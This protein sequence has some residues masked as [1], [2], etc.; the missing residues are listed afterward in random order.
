MPQS[1]AKLGPPFD[2]ALQLQ[3]GDGCERRRRTSQLEGHTDTRELHS[4][5]APRQ[6]LE[7]APPMPSARLGRP[8]D[9]QDWEFFTIFTA[10]RLVFWLAVVELPTASC[11][12]PAG[13]TEAPL[14]AAVLAAA[15]EWSGRQLSA[16]WSRSCSCVAQ[17]RG[18]RQSIDES[19]AL[20]ARLLGSSSEA[21]RRQLEGGSKRQR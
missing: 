2:G 19:S 14:F 10:T 7:A 9:A 16:V 17:S 13:A 8:L 15:L 18:G 11:R 3:L 21:A 20:L 12:R 5:G 6:H 4:E 1:R